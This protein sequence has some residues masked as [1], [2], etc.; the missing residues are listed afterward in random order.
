MIPKH[1]GKVTI[2]LERYLPALAAI[3]TWDHLIYGI[4]AV[5]KM[6]RFYHL[7]DGKIV[8]TLGPGTRV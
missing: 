6:V 3:Q 2:Q 7:V 1:S 8:Y 4:V 5:G